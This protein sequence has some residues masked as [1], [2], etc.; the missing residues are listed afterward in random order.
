MMPCMAL[1]YSPDHVFDAVRCSHQG[2]CRHGSLRDRCW[3]A[4][5]TAGSASHSHLHPRPAP[6]RQLGTQAPR[7]EPGPGWPLAPA[8]CAGATLRRTLR[9]RGQSAKHWPLVV[10]AVRVACCA[11]CF[12]ITT[13]FCLF[14]YAS[15]MSW[16][17]WASLR[18]RR[19]IVDSQ[20]PGARYRGDR[21]GTREGG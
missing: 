21:G 17:S 10:A 7:A 8:G 18:T 19:H 13:F 5:E 1:V 14:H 15:D 9:C 3:R 11:A 16:E 20:M 12:K 4:A 2:P 6:H